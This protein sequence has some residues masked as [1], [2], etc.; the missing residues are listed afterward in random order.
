MSTRYL[1]A[2]CLPKRAARIPATPLVSKPEPNNRPNTTRED[3]TMF[4]ATKAPPTIDARPLSRT[5]QRPGRS[6]FR[7]AAKVS[8]TPSRMLVVAT[9]VVKKA[10][11]S[12]GLKRIRYEKN[13]WAA[14]NRSDCRLSTLSPSP[15]NPD[16]TLKTEITAREMAIPLRATPVANIGRNKA[17]V[18]PIT[19]ETPDW[20]TKPQLR[21]S[22]LVATTASI[23][24]AAS[25]ASSSSTSPV[26]EAKA[27]GIFSTDLLV[28]SIP[29][30]RH[31]FPTIG[32]GETKPEQPEN[33]AAIA[34][35]ER[36]TL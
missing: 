3:S 30:G 19:L 25:T 12:N 26:L 2:I 13:A 32:F 29:F 35:K 8:K 31:I 23:S 10:R 11:L 9:R 4:V 22:S 14:P 17:R 1:L 24:K 5:N 18:P 34:R 7:R 16:I 28:G 6:A 15:V 27:T 36:A 20:N 21:A 33:E